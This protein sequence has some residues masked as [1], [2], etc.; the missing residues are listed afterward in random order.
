MAS[1]FVDDLSPM[2]NETQIS[3]MPRPRLLTRKQVAQRLN[4]HKETI[5]RWGRCGKLKPIV[6]S[7]NVV[8]YDETEVDSLISS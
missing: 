6:L 4:V 8:R 1:V 7:Q 3:E 5:K 2:K